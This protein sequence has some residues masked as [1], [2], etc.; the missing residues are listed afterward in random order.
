MAG[1]PRHRVAVTPLV[2]PA[3]ARSPDAAIESVWASTDNK[4]SKQSAAVAAIT[5]S[6]RKEPTA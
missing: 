2:T 5:V 1:A 4:R 3:I 6:R